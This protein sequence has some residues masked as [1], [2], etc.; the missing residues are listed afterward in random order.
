[1]GLQ[2]MLPR[3]AVPALFSG[4]PAPAMLSPEEFNL[5]SAEL[6]ARAGLQIFRVPCQ[7]QLYWDPTNISDP[8]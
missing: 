1:M 5:T 2:G 4:F 6:A 7:A 3:E 8:M